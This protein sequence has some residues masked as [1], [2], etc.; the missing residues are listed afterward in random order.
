MAAFMLSAL[1]QNCRVLIHQ[2]TP[3]RRFS[4]DES[5]TSTGQN[6]QQDAGVELGV[7][8]EGTRR[9]PRL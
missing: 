4:G 1:T 9:D 7:V 8:V 6:V 3:L 5:F 2:L